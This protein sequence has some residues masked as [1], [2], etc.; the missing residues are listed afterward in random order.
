M[1]EGSKGMGTGMISVVLWLSHP[2]DTGQN[3]WIRLNSRIPV[4][5]S[6]PPYTSLRVQVCDPWGAQLE[7]MRLL[8][9]HEGAEC[10]S[11]TLD[12]S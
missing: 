7:P 1:K 5:Q 4:L 9:H 12:S 11:Q 10:A 8:M 6:G 2:G 3:H